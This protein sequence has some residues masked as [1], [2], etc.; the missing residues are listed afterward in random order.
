MGSTPSNSSCCKCNTNNSLERQINTV[1]NKKSIV[2]IQSI[3]RGFIFRKKNPE[4]YRNINCFSIR[5]SSS[6]SDLSK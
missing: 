4:I 5:G 6:F 3:Y 1:E 2:K